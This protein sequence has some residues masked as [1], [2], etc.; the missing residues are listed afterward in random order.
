MGRAFRVIVVQRP[1]FSHNY[2]LL[3]L[4]RYRFS[5]TVQRISNLKRNRKILRRRLW[6]ILKRTG[7]GWFRVNPDGSIKQVNRQMI[8]ILAAHSLKQIQMHWSKGFSI[9]GQRQ[10]VSIERLD[11]RKVWLDIE[12]FPDN[13]GRMADVTK[14]MEAEVHLNFW[15]ITTP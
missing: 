5:R 1:D 6:R 7:E 13:T 11:G 15:H 8:K 2:V 14:R 10:L 4:E 9:E 12:L 3:A